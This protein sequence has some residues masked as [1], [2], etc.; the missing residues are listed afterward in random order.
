MV[1][2]DDQS[3]RCLFPAFASDEPG[4]GVVNFLSFRLWWE[5]PLACI[6]FPYASFDFL[7]LR[8]LGG[9][10]HRQASILNGLASRIIIIT[11]IIGI[12]FYCFLLLPMFLFT[13]SSLP[14]IDSCYLAFARYLLMCAGVLACMDTCRLY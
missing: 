11:I 12:I 13:F 10:V 3:F 6:L 9:I 7:V 2:S 14:L 4:A 1:C 5:S 8:Y